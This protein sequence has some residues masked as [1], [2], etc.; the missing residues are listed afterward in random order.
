MSRYR[1]FLRRGRDI[2]VALPALWALAAA[3]CTSEPPPCTSVLNTYD[4]EELD[5]PDDLRDVNYFRLDIDGANEAENALGMAL[6]E[7]THV[8][9]RYTGRPDELLASARDEGRFFLRLRVETCEDEDRPATAQLV[10]F[11]RTGPGDLEELP[12]MPPVIFGEERGQP[13]P[14]VARDGAAKVPLGLVFDGTHSSGENGWV[15]AAGFALSVTYAAAEGRGR[16]NGVLGFGATAEQLDDVVFPTIARTLSELLA[17][18][19]DDDDLALFDS[20]DDGVVS[21]GEVGE[22]AEL[23]RLEPDLDLFSS[24]SGET[25]YAPGEDGIAESFSFSLGFRAGRSCGGDDWS[26][27]DP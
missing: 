25:V 15:T 17:A 22:V 27:L 12:A 4:L 9:E 26:C 16:M 18:H 5:L 23:A 2:A 6:S 1:W 24:A 8:I 21:S 10:A 19:P 14:S 13:F 11:E 7:Y 20:D 3:G